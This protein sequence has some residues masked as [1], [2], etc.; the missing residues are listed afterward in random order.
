MPRSLAL[1]SRMSLPV[2]GFSVAWFDPPD[3]ASVPKSRP[4]EV[5]V[6]LP[7]PE[8]KMDSTQ[9]YLH[10]DCSDASGDPETW[11]RY[12]ASD[13]ERPGHPGNPAQPRVSPR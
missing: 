13:E 9:S 2:K 3:T 8:K 11:L 6:P 5:F 1:S 10:W 4:K 12:Y 7:S